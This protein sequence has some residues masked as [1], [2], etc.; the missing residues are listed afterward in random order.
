MPTYNLSH[1][2]WLAVPFW[3]RCRTYLRESRD[4]RFT[5]P[6]YAVV[7]YYMSF[8]TRVNPSRLP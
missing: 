3:I 8:N 5:W 6:V 4:S 7:Q 1:G 2:D